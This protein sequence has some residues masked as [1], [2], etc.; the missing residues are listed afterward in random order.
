M[1]L[2]ALIGLAL[3]VGACSPAT[4]NGDIERAKAAGQP[5]VQSLIDYKTS[6]G[7]YPVSFEEAGIKPVVTEL[8]VF[9]YERWGS[10]D[11]EY[12]VVHVGDYGRNG[13]VL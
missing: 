9:E 13:F 1:R 4:S 10:E 2:L 11:E 8:G 12:V 5:I 7:R 3:L 6:H